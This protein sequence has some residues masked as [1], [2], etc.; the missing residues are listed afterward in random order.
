M[1]RL[2]RTAEAPEAPKAGSATIE[3]AIKVVVDGLKEMGVR[4]D[5]IVLVGGGPLNEQSA[6]AVGAD[7]YCPDASVALE[8]AKA[9]R[10]KPIGPG[11]I[12]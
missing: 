12:E 5:Y 10:A 4:D 2:N 9:L 3:N 1:L 8:T 11:V 7:A 6:L